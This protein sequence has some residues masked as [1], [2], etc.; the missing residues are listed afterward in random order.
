MRGATAHR[1]THRKAW[2]TYGKNRS[3]RRPAGKGQAPRAH[4]TI[5][6]HKKMRSNDICSGLITLIGVL[7]TL[8][9]GSCQLQ[10]P[11]I[12]ANTTSAHVHLQAS[13]AAALATWCN[14][15]PQ[16]YRSLKMCSPYPN[17]TEHHTPR[18]LAPSPR[19]SL[20][21]AI[22]HL[23]QSLKHSVNSPRPRPGQ[24]LAQ[25][26]APP[27]HVAR[28]AQFQSARTSLTAQHSASDDP[29]QQYNLSIPPSLLD[30]AAASEEEDSDV[31]S[32]DEQPKMP[33]FVRGSRTCNNRQSRNLL[34]AGNI[35]NTGAASGSTVMTSE[36][37][38]GGGRAGLAAQ[39][40]R[41][42][43]PIM[44]LQ[45]PDDPRDNPFTALGLLI[46]LQAN[47]RCVSMHSVL[48]V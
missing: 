30:L 29:E 12:R 38:W 28:A 21:S 16:R 42:L 22:A 1:T 10:I 35:P 11:S 31:P 19:G 17:I 14:R 20:A 9:S 39:C 5:T 15:L 48:G 23:W 3:R 13:A 45:L 46:A 44:H 18:V 26:P 8:D 32:Q 47:S 37:I 34:D 2:K 4:A 27:I 6:P 43:D 7:I 24:T 33:V 41:A 36:N 40:K 25:Q